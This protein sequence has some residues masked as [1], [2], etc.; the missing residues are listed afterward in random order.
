MSKFVKC[1]GQNKDDCSE[2]NIYSSSHSLHYDN[3][4]KKKISEISCSIGGNRKF[5]E[6]GKRVD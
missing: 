3:Y 1:I 5:N 2:C 4:L 6:E